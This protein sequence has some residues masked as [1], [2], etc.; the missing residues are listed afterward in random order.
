MRRRELLLGVAAVLG[1][2]S[3]RPARAAVESRQGAFEADVGILFGALS[4]HLAGTIDE[5]L[6]RAA[7]RYEVKLRGQGES[8]EHAVES[9]G[10]LREGR[11]APARTRSRFLV[12]G[13]ESHLAVAYDWDRRSID[14]R[15]RSET[16]FL[17]PA[18]Y[19]EKFPQE[20]QIVLSPQLEARIR[21]QEAAGQLIFEAVD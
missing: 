1:A 3:W 20:R 21:A 17:R 11:W 7:G 18:L 8:I 15:S 5:A 6:D 19:R 9:T 4:F 16:F 10:L 14:Y 2:G 13:R 12:H